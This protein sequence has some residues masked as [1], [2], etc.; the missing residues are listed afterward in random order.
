MGS[1]DKDPTAPHQPL[2]SSLVVRPTDSGGGGGGGGSDYEPGEVR[3]DPPPILALIDFLIIAML[4]KDGWC[5]N[6]RS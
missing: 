6:L 1:R 3:R 2:L 5:K 4:R